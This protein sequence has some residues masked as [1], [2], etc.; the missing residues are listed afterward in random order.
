MATNAKVNVVMSDKALVKKLQR[1]LARLESEL[2]CA[3]TT[4]SSSDSS[5]LIREK[6]LQIEKVIYLHYVVK[7]GLPQLGYCITENHV[8]HAAEER[9][10]R[11][12][13][14]ARRCSVSGERSAKSS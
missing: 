2:S 12:H 6:D 13:T 4:T 14:T 7:F 11:G 5:D 3:G 8:L 9:S 1:E 10:V